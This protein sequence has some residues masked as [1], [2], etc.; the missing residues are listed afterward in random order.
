MII[1]N[2]NR[3]KY[4]HDSDRAVDNVNTVIELNKHGWKCII[5]Y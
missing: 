5:S 2:C 3:Y 4:V 1:N